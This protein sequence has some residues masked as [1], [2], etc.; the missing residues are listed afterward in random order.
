MDEAATLATSALQG[1]HPSHADKQPYLLELLSQYRPRPQPRHLI[2]DP[3]AAAPTYT[4]LENERAP[5]DI[6]RLALQGNAS[7]DGYD[8]NAAATHSRKLEFRFSPGEP[9]HMKG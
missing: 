5:H 6:Q 7:E 4:A 2:E 3:G 8:V 9:K 1:P